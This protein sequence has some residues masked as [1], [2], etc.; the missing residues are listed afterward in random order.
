MAANAVVTGIDPGTWRVTIL[1]LPR[2]FSRGAAL[3]FCGG[4]PVGR[5][6]T[7]R[8]KSLGCWWPGGN[9]ELLA[10]EG[11]KELATSHAGGEA[12]PGHWRSAAGAMG[13]VRWD[14]RG[15]NLVATELHD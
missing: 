5:A 4:H 2:R 10:L 8:A 15:G 12:I 13:A 6:E 1:P 14:L 9:P 11:F 7:A 3:G